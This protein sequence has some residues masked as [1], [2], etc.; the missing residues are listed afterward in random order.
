MVIENGEVKGVEIARQPRILPNE[1]FEDELIEADVVISTT[2]GVARPQRRP[3][4]ELPD[5]YVGQIKFLAQDKFRIAWLGLY[6]AVDEPVP[7]LDRRELFDVAPHRRP[8]A[9]PASCSS[10]RRSTRRPRPRGK[11]ST[12]PAG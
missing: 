3:E 4:W 9:S 7:V 5:W 10:R 12:S 1:R 11:S 8:A 2:P 6:L